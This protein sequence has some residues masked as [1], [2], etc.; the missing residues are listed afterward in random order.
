MTTATAPEVVCVIEGALGHVTLNRPRAINA[1][2]ADMV[3][4]IATALDAWE[5]DDTV[6][7]VL[8][9]GAGERGLCAGGDIRTLYASARARNGAAEAFWRAEYTLNARIKR[10]PK[11]IVAFMDGIVMGGGV[12]VSAHAAVRVVTERSQVGMP[13]TGIG[14]LP[15]VGG[16]YL[17]SRAPGLLGTHAA[18]TSHRLGA[19]DALL[20]GLAD[21]HVP[22][23]DLPALAEKLRAGA[24]PGE[25][26][27]SLATPP[28]EGTLD[29]DRL[30]IDAAYAQATVVE[31]LAALQARPEPAARAAADAI[32]TKSP[33]S[34]AVTLRALEQAR[35]L[36]DLETC[37]DH[38]YR[39][40]C[41]LL[42]GHDFTEGVRAAVID[43]DRNPQ[44]LPPT[45]EE[46][47]PETVAACFAPRP[48][49]ELGLGRSTT[50]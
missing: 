40:A 27:A 44:W 39:A 10:Y 15:D 2:T 47:A 24:D 20:C 5:R 43:K 22:A 32:R 28:T 45:P 37:L 46:V 31:V 13:E 34:L 1:L 14:F 21:H 16:T 3:A 26:A 29:R 35:T 17:L 36:P 38:E 50:A 42:A 19:A 30:W 49:D 11:P 4:D 25:A 41:A 48:G 7:C 18:L 23:D 33:T 6:R 9:D 12:G 8:V